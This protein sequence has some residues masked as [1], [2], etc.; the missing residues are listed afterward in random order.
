LL[1]NRRSWGAVASARVDFLNASLVSPA[2]ERRLD[3]RIHNRL[4]L[5]H[6]HHSLSNRENV[7][8]IVSSAKPRRFDIPAKSASYATHTVRDDRLTVSRS[9]EYDAS[10]VFSACDCFCNR[11]NEQRVINRF[12]GVRSHV[13]HF[14]SRCTKHLDDQPLVF[15]PGMIG[16]N[17]NLVSALCHCA[18]IYQRIA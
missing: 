18:E 8:I 4:H 15:K 7:R 16:S 5:V 12:I 17:R 10:L 1:E 3:P 13:V 11:S 14:V 2:F 9:A 6:A